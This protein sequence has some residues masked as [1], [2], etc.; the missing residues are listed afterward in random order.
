MPMHLQEDNFY[1]DKL[2]GCYLNYSG[3]KWRHMK[4]IHAL[5]PQEQEL[6]ALDL[7]CGG[8]GVA[9]HMPSSWE[10]TA[11]DIEQRLINI[12]HF[13]GDNVEHFLDIADNLIDWHG[14]DNKNQ[15]GFES[16]R[17]DY[18]S[19][20]DYDPSIPVDLYLLICHSFSNQI[21]FNAS[22]EFNLPFGKRTFNKSMREKLI[23]FNQRC[24]QRDIAFV[25]R[26]FRDFNLDKYNFVFV[27]CPYLETTATYNEKG[28]WGVEEET[29]LL[30]KLE[31]TTAKWML[32]NQTISKGKENKLLV[33]FIK[34]GGYNVHIL[35][36]T[37]KNCNYQR[38]GGETVEF[39]V[40]NY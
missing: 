7:F 36:D 9:S 16:L 6:K 5:L 25:S 10:I 23:R 26:D 21:R 39:I 35:K 30:T 19:I 24:A 27:D 11:N 20:S 12:H 34:R 1:K 29:V 40:T 17:S 31:N 32:T 28:G 37:T 38:K 2:N 18:N 3:S 14:L 15:R 8:A 13:V 33:D 22:G 4:E